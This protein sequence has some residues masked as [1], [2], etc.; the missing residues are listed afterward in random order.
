MREALL[1]AEFHVEV[2][3]VEHRPTKLTSGEGEGSGLKGWVEL[4]GA[5]FLEKVDVGK[6]RTVVDRVCD[7][8]E[9][10]VTREE[11]GSQW[12]GYVRLRGV[13]RRPASDTFEKGN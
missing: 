8:L 1:D 4:M 11:D 6:R 2:L 7:L 13:A 12:L 5:E 9:T 10:V 3:E